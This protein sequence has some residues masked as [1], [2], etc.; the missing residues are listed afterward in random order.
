MLLPFNNKWPGSGPFGPK[1]LTADRQP[2]VGDNASHTWTLSGT[3][4]NSVGAPVVNAKINI[5]RTGYF[6]GTTDYAGNQIIYADCLP[7]APVITYT[8]N[9][10]TFASTGA[11]T[12]TI[13]TSSGNFINAGFTVGQVIT[14][15][16]SL[17]NNITSGLIT[18]ITLSTLTLSN[19]AAGV[20]SGSFFTEATGGSYNVTLTGSITSPPRVITQLG[21]TSGASSYFI[22]DNTFTRTTSGSAYKLTSTSASTFYWAFTN[23]SESAVTSGNLSAGHSYALYVWVYVPGLP[24][25]ITLSTISTIFGTSINGS[26]FVTNS[27]NVPA[28]YSYWQQLVL[29]FTVPNNAT[30]NYLI[31][32]VN[33]AIASSIW[34]TDVIL[35]DLTAQAIPLADTIIVTTQSL[36]DGTWSV[37][38][39]SGAYNYYV[40]AYYPNSPDLVSVSTN[41]LR[42]S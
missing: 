24:S 41:T 37:Q 25:S 35:I 36:S 6:A 19:I 4:L 17:Y 7:I 40:I 32:N 26:T 27:S 8:R 11:N 30:G 23:P 12:G 38:M 39:P 34:V 16:N 13:T 5:F 15:K 28:A 21:G 29:N 3:A 10:L 18:T 9:D 31:L 14:V 22:Q 33:Q 1:R 20:L 2:N 42:P